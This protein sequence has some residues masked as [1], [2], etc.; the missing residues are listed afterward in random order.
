[1]PDDDINDDRSERDR[2][3]SERDNAADAPPLTFGIY[4]G[5][6]ARAED[7]KQLGPLDDPARINEALAT[8]QGPG[9][10]FI[11]RSYLSFDGSS[12]DAIRAGN[13]APVDLHQYCGDGRK[14]DLVLC[15]WDAAG[16]ID[17][18]CEFVRDAL[19]RYGPVLNFLQIAEEPDLY[20]Y[21]GDGRFM[22]QV[23]PAILRGVL[24]AKEEA[25]RLNLDVKIGFNA[26]PCFN[27]N[28]PFWTAFRAAI[29]P[30]FLDALDYVG[31]DFFP[32]VYRPLPPDGTPGDLRESV[33]ALLTHFREIMMKS[34][35]I[36][37]SVPLHI[38]E[39]GWPTSPT[40][41]Y[42]RQAEVLEI[43][44]RTIHGLRQTLNITHY[45]HFDLRDSDNTLP[46]L[47]AF[48]L[49]R[50]DYTPKPAFETY[51]RLI[52]ELGS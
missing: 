16:D 40:R 35:G 48:G 49:L 18:W 37:P 43:V 47:H 51:R 27:P 45:E 41:P 14:L 31:F 5:G 28:D 17:R 44:V 26:A 11:V 6:P 29:D 38:G 4:H 7:G 39:N 50:D 13:P 36:A 2:P 8:L 52:A 12:T 10:P 9:R 46:D 20:T 32:D 34:A 42:E 23:V 22:P 33:I 19:R 24:A 15:Y 3:A 30:P 1:M 25:A 21:P